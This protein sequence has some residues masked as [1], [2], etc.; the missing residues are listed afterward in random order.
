MQICCYCH[1]FLSQKGYLHLDIKPDNIY[2]LKETNQIINL[3][4]FDTVKLKSDLENGNYIASTN[5]ISAPEISKAE[6]D[7]FTGKYLQEVDERADIYAIG[8][9][10]LKRLWKEMLKAQTLYSAKNLI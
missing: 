9:I 10:L 5:K 1:R 4:D 2:V 3:F 8:H 7:E 6:I